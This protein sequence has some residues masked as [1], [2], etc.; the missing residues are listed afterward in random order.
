MAITLTTVNQSQRDSAGV[1]EHRL[2][3][4]ASHVLAVEQRRLRALQV[5]TQSSPAVD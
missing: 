2:A 3:L 1:A 4:V 5:L